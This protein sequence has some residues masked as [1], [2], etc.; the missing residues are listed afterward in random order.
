ME[1]K[2]LVAQEKIEQLQMELKLKDQTQSVNSQKSS[3][4]RFV[5]AEIQT[6]N[7]GQVEKFFQTESPQSE[8]FQ[9]HTNIHM[10]NQSITTQTKRTEN[11][12]IEVQVNI[13]REHEPMPPLR[14]IKEEIAMPNLPNS[15]GQT[16]AKK[17]KLSMVSRSCATSTD[18]DSSNPEQNLDAEI[19]NSEVYKIYCRNEDP[20]E[21]MKQIQELKNFIA[22]YE[23]VH[24]YESDE[25][26]LKLGF[27]KTLENLWSFGPSGSSKWTHIKHTVNLNPDDKEKICIFERP[28]GCPPI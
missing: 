25:E 5:D 16:Q 17:R 20:K 22:F 13:Q 21:A 27:E 23:P 18:F 19:L 12:E 3:S 9:N 6:D 14:T 11:N 7:F 1:F 26:D 24:C 4:I 8:D 15:I 2:Y 28:V 10:E